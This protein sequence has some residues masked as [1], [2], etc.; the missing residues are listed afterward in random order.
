MTVP[1]INFIEG[2]KW[3]LTYQHMIVLTFSWL[4]FLL[5]LGVIQIGYFHYLQ[6]KSQSIEQEIIVL[7][8]ETVFAAQKM[9]AMLKGQGP[10][11][12]RIYN[13]FERRVRWSP[14]LTELT[15]R[16]PPRLWLVEVSSRDKDS[17][18]KVLTLMGLTHQT[19]VLSEFLR[20]LSGIKNLKNIT[21]LSSEKKEEGLIRFSIQ[22][23]F[24]P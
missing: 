10:G 12:S 5:F 4:G 19:P 24:L 20:S 7:K 2:R 14:L 3:V 6:W 18:Q 22:S 17:E 11:Y 9:T 15:R 23:D 16:T 8:S 1:R 13:L 21:L